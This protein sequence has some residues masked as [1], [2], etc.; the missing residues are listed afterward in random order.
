MPLEVIWSFA[1]IISIFVIA[2]ILQRRNSTKLRRI[3]K[4]TASKRNAKIVEAE[5]LSLP[6]LIFNHNKLAVEVCSYPPRR[7]T[8]A[9]T[10]IETEISTADKH[11]IHISPEG[12]FSTLVKN[13]S[14]GEIQIG[15][16]KFDDSFQIKTND[17][18]FLRSILD[19]KI[20]HELLSLKQFAP[21]LTLENGRLNLTLRVRIS[22]EKM[23]DNFLR[24]YLAILNKIAK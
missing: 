19:R 8:V 6:T 4:R 24:I 11:S 1:P 18:S 15:Y 5:F 20:Q 13:I 23:L 7:H 21:S 10:Q 9:S 3:F 22:D 2:Y 16:S 12:I 14:G 17:K